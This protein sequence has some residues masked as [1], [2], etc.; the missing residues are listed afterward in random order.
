MAG[1]LPGILLAFLFICIPPSPYS[2]R[3]SHLPYN[4]PRFSR[5][6][7]SVLSIIHSVRVRWHVVIVP[8]V[9]VLNEMKLHSGV[10]RIQ[11]E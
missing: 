4:V 9:C 1:P 7:T 3:T 10:I 2:H 8:S 6:F 5:N 11:V